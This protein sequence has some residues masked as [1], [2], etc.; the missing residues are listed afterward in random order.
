LPAGSIYALPQP[1][2]SLSKVGGEFG[3]PV[4]V[5]ARQID[6]FNSILRE[7]AARAGAHYVDLSPRMKEQARAGMF[8]DDGL[9]PSAKAY[10]EWAA[11]LAERIAL[12]PD[13]GREPGP[14]MR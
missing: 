1:D 6:L 3:M 12:P 11:I 14:A 7:E 9:H 4:D 13:A 10:D 2:W 5:I 8:A